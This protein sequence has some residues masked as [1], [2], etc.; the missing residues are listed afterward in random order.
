ML[1]R[2]CSRRFRVPQLSV[3]APSCLHTC[4][5][6]LAKSFVDGENNFA[7]NVLVRLGNY[8]LMS[9]CPALPEVVTEPASLAT[10]VDVS[11]RQLLEHLQR[12]AQYC[13]GQQITISDVRFD[14][15]VDLFLDR[16]STLTDEELLST[17][18]ILTIF[19]ATQGV[20]ARNFL[21]MWTALDD[22][23]LRRLDDWSTEQRLLACDHWFKLNMA[24][25][26]KFPM[27]STKRLGRNLRR[28]SPSQLVQTLFYVN[29]LRKTTLEMFPFEERLAKV[30]DDLSTDEIAIMS[31]GFFKTQTKLNIPEVAQKVYE[32]L[33]E[34]CLTLPDISLTAILKI[35]RYS[36]KLTDAPNVVRIQ[37]RLM[38]RIPELS[39]LSCLHLALLGTS[40]QCCDA[41]CV[42]AVIKRFNKDYKNGRLKDFERIAF[43]MA[44]FDVDTEDS[45]NLCRSI[46]EEI[47]NR[48]EDI[49][50]YKRC[51]PSLL[52]SLVMCG[53]FDQEMIHVALSKQFYEAAY[54]QNMLLGRDIF[55]LDSFTR[56]ELQSQYKGAQLTERQRR[57][58]AKLLCN[59]LPDKDSKYK[60]SVSDR[61]LLET[62]EALDNI[63]GS[64]CTVIENL[65]P[66]FNG[67]DIMIA[68]NAATEQPLEVRTLHMPEVYSGIILSREELLKSI[69]NAEDVRLVA[70]VF[71]GFNAY[72]RGTEQATGTLRL[73]IKQ[74]KQIGHRVVEVS[75]REVVRLY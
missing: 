45:N 58:Y 32:R 50:K 57:N 41:E 10:P 28:L 25:V 62:K 59:Y 35:L 6:T 44:L 43:V 64:Q 54:G 56:I 12:T 49:M 69:D 9:S 48:K 26:A 18:R 36:A 65:L 3:T 60:K 47:P 29:M 34:D 66:H 42:S 46:L 53:H 20:G 5:T 61:C 63:Y 31:M 74:L 33:Y 15:I 13:R 51:Y 72:V 14:G 22:E 2:L 71:G 75:D 4:S 39:L 30:I 21:E 16:I 52:N 11:N 70:V 27:Q 73:K 40:F 55:C 67:P 1:L 37:Q 24:K 68:F 19:P 17:V 38:R 8:N 23:C 7:H